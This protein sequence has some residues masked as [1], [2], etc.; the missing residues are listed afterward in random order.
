MTC[1]HPIAAYRVDGQVVI[2]GKRG[3]ESGSFFLPCGRCVGCLAERARQWTVRIV[4]EA[5]L[6]K[7]NCAVT[8]T[9]DD[10]HVPEDRGLHY[11]DVQ[12]FLKRLRGRR[13]DPLRYFAAG[14]YGSVRGRPHWH[15]CLFNCDFPDQVKSA[16]YLS[17]SK[18]LE[19]LWS[20]GLSA[21]GVLDARTAAYIAGYVVKKRYGQ[22]ESYQV[23]DPRTGEIMDR[24]PEFVHMSLR[25]AIGR[26]WIERY[27]SD[28]YPRGKLV[29]EGRE[30]LPPR[31]YDKRY[32]DV[33][34][35][36][37]DNLQHLR[38]QDARQRAADNTLERLA[39]KEVV[40]KAQ[41]GSLKR[42]L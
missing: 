7:R 23:V 10:E 4:H 31:Y 12:K 19:E 40:K 1:Y 26:A 11:E 35:Y 5:S 30:V 24:L 29:F 22:R 21:I 41:V 8:L 16:K 36:Q 3:Q 18:E 39:V 27:Q 28:V 17:S 9:Y 38:D 20:V 42:K 33:A 14:E 32:K 25:P 2:Q 37:Y 15:L 6:H 34:P 13:R